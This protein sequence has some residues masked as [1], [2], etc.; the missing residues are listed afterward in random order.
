MDI[1]ARVVAGLGRARPA[2][3]AGAWPGRAQP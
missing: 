3:C 2:G 1:T